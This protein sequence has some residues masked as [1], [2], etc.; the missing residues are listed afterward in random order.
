MTVLVGVIESGGDSIL[1]LNIN[2]LN[3]KT[4][5][6]RVSYHTARSRNHYCCGKAVSITHSEGVFVALVIQHAKHIRRIILSYVPCLALPVFPHYLIN[7]M[8]CKKKKSNMCAL[9]FSTNLS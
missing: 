8:I 9:I 5:S 2:K 6:V 3:N 4:G 7:G 1:K